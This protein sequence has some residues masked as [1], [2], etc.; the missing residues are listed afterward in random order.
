VDIR[1][2][3]EAMKGDRSYADLAKA[4]G[5]KPTRQ[6]W[7]QLATDQPKQF[8]EPETIHGIAAA[9]RVTPLTVVHAFAESFGIVVKDEPRLVQLLP[10]GIERLS[11]DDVRQVVNIAARLVPDSP[12]KIARL[13]DR[14]DTPKA[15]PRGEAAS[16]K[17]GGG[18]DRGPGPIG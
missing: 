11:D 3:I 14:R 17:R 9:L 12:A 5:N 10:P 8:P 7:Q 6:R 13:S 18:R 1:A 15:P 4:S 2:L 16:K